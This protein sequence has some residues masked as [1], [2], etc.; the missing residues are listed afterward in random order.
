MTRIFINGINGRMGQIAA[1]GIEKTADLYLVGGASSY[2]QLKEC[3]STLHTDLI[4]DLTRAS[5][6]MR[7]VQLIMS[8]QIPLVLGT[9]GITKEKQQKLKHWCTEYHTSCWQIPNFSIGAVLM[10]NAAAQAAK[11]YQTALIIERHHS[12]KHDQPS[13]TAIATRQK[14]QPHIQQ[15]KIESHRDDRY[16]AEQEILLSNQYDKLRIEHQVFDRQNYL[17]GILFACRQMASIQGF[18]YGLHDA[19][20]R[21]RCG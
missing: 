10:M 6:V 9:S 2:D 18:Q 20:N 12:Q 21:F 19:L 1:Q 7:H 4:L 11:F 15:I 8:K 17:P 16:M 13:Q 14:I 3:I 5:N